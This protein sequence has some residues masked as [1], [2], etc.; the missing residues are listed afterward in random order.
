MKNKGKGCKKC[1]TF[2]K[3]LLMCFFICLYVCM[4][5]QAHL[6]FMTKEQERLLKRQIQI[7]KVDI[8]LLSLPSC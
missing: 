6:L 1:C 2:G 7:N 8:I 5:F 4:Q 3:T